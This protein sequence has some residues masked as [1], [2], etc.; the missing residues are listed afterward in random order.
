MRSL[1]RLDRKILHE[2]DLNARQSLSQIAKKL[3]LGSDLI[4]YRVQKYLDE[5]IISR[6]SPIISP[7]LL[8]VN[9]CK[10][11]IKHRMPKQSLANFLAT[12]QKHPA[13]Y[14]LCEG[15]G[16]WDILF[17]FATPSSREFQ[18]EQDKIL[19][20][21]G[22]YI[23]DLTVTLPTEVFRFPKHYLVGKG[24]NVFRWKRSAPMQ[25]IDSL[26]KNILEHLSDNCRINTSVLAKRL[27]TTPAIVSYRI[28][29]M[30]KAG[31]ILGYRT[32]F[33]YNAI[34]MMLFKVLLELRS[35][36][37]KT[38]KDI[39]NYCQNE[40]HITCFIQQIANTQIEFEVEANDYQ[41]FISIIENF[42]ENFSSHLGRVEYMLI[43]KDHYHRIPSTMPVAS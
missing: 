6:F 16:A 33:D 29:K 35:F 43:K 41:Q 31:L 20:K 23:I 40:P 28:E 5:G 15:Y 26:E 17:S 21:Y 39:L 7:G 22:K 2:L 11:Y 18:K 36:T 37:P 3:R 32:Q 12:I 9:I 34:E 8:G 4:E 27:K 13:T 24:K 42:K 30:E 1:D 19:S 25:K 10:T 38:R 14:W